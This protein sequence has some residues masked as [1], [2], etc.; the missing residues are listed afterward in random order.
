MRL[1]DTEALVFVSEQSLELSDPIDIAIS[2]HGVSE[3]LLGGLGILDVHVTHEF[4]NQFETL[5]IGGIEMSSD[6]V[7]RIPIEPQGWGIH[8]REDLPN[9]LWSLTPEVSVVLKK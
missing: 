7:S 4:T 6:Q 2:H 5:R 8:A 9:C 3:P 1:Y